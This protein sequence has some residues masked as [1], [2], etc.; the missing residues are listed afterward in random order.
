[1][2]DFMTKEKLLIKLNEDIKNKLSSLYR[3]SYIKN[4]KL[5]GKSNTYYH[6]V[7]AEYLVNHEIIFS[8]I[9]PI[10]RR[11]KNK[12]YLTES[13]TK[14]IS[15]EKLFA[16]SLMGSEID[17]LGKIIDFET[18]INSSNKDNA[19]E[20]DLLSYNDK[21]NTLFLIELKMS[22]N[23]ETLL[24]SILEISTYYQQIELQYL[25]EDFGYTTAAVK[26][27]VLIFKDSP[28]H[29][30]YVKSEHIR[31]LAMKLEVE[32]LIIDMKINE[33]K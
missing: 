8:N 4:P 29:Q 31:E 22:S 1:M 24:R 30:Q 28:L 20:I 5:I 26:K 19:G 17:Y 15:K 14:R 10:S 27:V 7:I 18:P 16:K 21:K 11:D 33:V 3:E 2:E 23:T 12:S 32:I 13:H 6:D 25:K 9:S